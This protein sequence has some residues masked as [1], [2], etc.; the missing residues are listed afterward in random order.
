M[1]SSSMNSCNDSRMDSCNDSRM[2]SCID[3]KKM[4]VCK[5]SPSEFGDEDS[6]NISPEDT[7]DQD[8]KENFDLF[9]YS[10]WKCMKRINSNLN[11]LAQKFNDVESEIV[12][13][14][15][16]DYDHF[17]LMFPLKE[18]KDVIELESR[19]ADDSSDFTQKFVSY[20]TPVDA[21]HTMQLKNFVR[22]MLRTLFTYC[23]AGKFSWRGFRG[24]FQIEH[25]KTIKLIFVLF[26]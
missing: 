5:K 9:A 20:I 24:N 7:T 10:I 6:R 22:T 18:L 11:F 25:L 8:S 3:S 17:L 13:S 21:G 2:D 23:L 12:P 4:I 1:S 26:I 16:L 14:S 19:L 15:T